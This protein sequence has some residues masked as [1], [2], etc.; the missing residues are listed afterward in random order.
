MIERV[1]LYGYA[2]DALTFLVI[3]AADRWLRR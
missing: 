2:V 1:L 3:V